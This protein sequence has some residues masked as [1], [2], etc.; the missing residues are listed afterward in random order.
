MRDSF[1]FYRGFYEAICELETEDQATVYNA[2][3]K[4]SLDGIEPELTGVA[5]AMF[6]MAKPQID[7]GLHFLDGQNGRR[8]AEYS[9]WR[10]RVFLRDNFTCQNCGDRGGKLNAHHI[11]SYAKYPQL[12]YSVQNGITLCEACHREVHHGKK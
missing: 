9:E 10:Q 6:K 3:C 8:S 11:K 5:A 7:R 4:Y 1:V 12:R 2:I